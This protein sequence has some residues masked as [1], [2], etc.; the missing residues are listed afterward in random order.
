MIPPAPQTFWQDVIARVAALVMESERN[1]GSAPQR[2]ER[3]GYA[4]TPGDY[5]RMRVVPGNPPDRPL[6]AETGA[7]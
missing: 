7:A 4:R 6:G 1:T 2:A 5:E 3:P